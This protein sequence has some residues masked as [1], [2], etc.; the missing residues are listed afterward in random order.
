MVRLFVYSSDVVQVV[1]KLLSLFPDEI[2]SQ[3]LEWIYKFSRNTKISYRV[4]ALDL[5]SE[6]LCTPQRTPPEG[7]LTHTA[8]AANCHHVIP[9]HTCRLSPY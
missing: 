2:Y 1:C 6:L 7:K 9:V 3:L 4:F 8:T 5:L